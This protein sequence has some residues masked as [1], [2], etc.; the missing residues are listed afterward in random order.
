MRD[1]AAVREFLARMLGWSDDRAVEL[2]LRSVELAA[3]GDTALALVGSGDL[4]PIAQA[5]HR[6]VRGPDRPFIVADP[7]RGD[8]LA[9]PRAPAS[10][11]NAVMAFE[12]ARRGTFCLRPRREPA[13]LPEV[14]PELR[15]AEDV[16][17]I[18]CADT[19]TADSS[20]MIRPAPVVVPPLAGRAHEL[21][22]IIAEYADEAIA[23]LEL[24]EFPA[25]DREWVLQN[26]ATSFDEIDKATRRLAM[27]RAT[28]SVT[29]AAYRLGMSQVSLSRW[30][31][32]R[33]LGEAGDDRDPGHPGPDRGN[34]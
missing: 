5:L 32:R 22:R 29:A 8:Q 34:L 18:L 25:A 23:D 30:L 1:A 6:R 7:R 4:V 15:T 12:A 31:G 20:L 16:M 13:D 27:V 33:R 17:L 10:R 3:A 26:A 2:A 28:G 11:G 21:P 14:A 19:R 9:S 24:A